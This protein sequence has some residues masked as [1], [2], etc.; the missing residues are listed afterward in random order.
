MEWVGWGDGMRGEVRVGWIWDGSGLEGG[1]F[2]VPTDRP[3]CPKARG[4]WHWACFRV[5]LK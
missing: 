5:Y 2:P 1:L 3:Q 4:G